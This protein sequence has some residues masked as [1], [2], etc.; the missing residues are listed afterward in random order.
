VRHLDLA[1]LT[2]VGA[3]VLATPMEIRDWGLLES[4]LARPR[5]TVF[6][7]DAYPSIWEKAA[8][9]MHSL[10]RN[11][12]LVDGNKRVGFTAGVLL[13]HKDTIDLSFGEDEAYVLVLAI[14]EGQV[15]VPEIAARLRGFSRPAADAAAD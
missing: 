2:A 6:G 3:Y 7:Q 8:A 1:D 15:D 5:T 10:I 13:L 9:L 11:H 12:A 4:A 14:A